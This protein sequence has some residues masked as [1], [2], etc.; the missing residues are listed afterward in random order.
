MRRHVLLGLGH[1]II[2]IPRVVWWRGV[3][4]LARSTTS[5]ASLSEEQHLV[6]DFVVREIPRAGEVLSPE[7]IGQALKLPTARVN[8]ILDEL[9]KGLVF[10]FRDEQGAVVWAYPVT[11]A[12]TPHHVTF[13]TGE[14]G[15]AA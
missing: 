7:F 1:S 14:Q 15:Y 2:P 11:A 8:A 3:S 12:R 4:T 9:E 13:S 6:R 10:L 5:T